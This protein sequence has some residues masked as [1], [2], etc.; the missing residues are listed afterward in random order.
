MA[1]LPSAQVISEAQFYMGLGLTITASFFIGSSFIIKKL[2]LNKLSSSGH[3]RASAGGF[4][5]LKEW[6][7]WAGLLT[8]GVGELANFS[9]YLFA[10]ASLVTPLGALSV[11]ITAVLASKFLNEKIFLLGK[12]GCFLCI[13]GS[14]IIVIHSP[15]EEEIENIEVLLEKIQEPAFIIYVL[16]VIA[17]SLSIVY[18]FGPRFGSRNVS[19]Y[20]I[21]C[22]SVGSL[23]VMACKGFGLA[24]KETLSGTRNEL[25]NYLTCISPVPGTR[26]ELDNSLTCIFPVSGTRNELGNSLTWIFLSLVIFCIVIQMTYLNKSLDLFS[27]GIVT[28]I[29]YVMFTTLVITASAI[30]FKEWTHLG[31]NDIIGNLC[32]FLVIICGIVLLN[33]FKDMDV[34]MLD[35]SRQ[36][37]SRRHS[38]KTM[39]DDEDEE[40]QDRIQ[41][42]PRT[43]GTSY[44]A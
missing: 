31:A 2:A 20:I 43:Y 30:L 40:E 4:G 19:V 16:L 33:T 18:Y 32:G 6:I 3:M 23:T 28:P 11:L 25:D 7:W 22:S 29:Y 5:Y 10:P 12:I 8:M 1:E 36:W 9:A 34:N 42:I 17:V 44:N 26:N 38:T 21:L 39:L 41:S 14:T 37:R 24:L 35:L 13:I 27:T 15:K